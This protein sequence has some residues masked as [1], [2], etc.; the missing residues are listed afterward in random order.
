MQVGRNWTSSGG[1]YALGH[2]SLPQHAVEGLPVARPRFA[3]PPRVRTFGAGYQVSPGVEAPERYI[4]A[5]SVCGTDLQPFSPW[6]GRLGATLGAKVGVEVLIT[7]PKRPPHRLQGP[8]RTPRRARSA[9]GMDCLHNS[10]PGALT[11]GET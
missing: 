2:F 8:L 11:P 10:R 1:M 5:T 6:E 4:S 7:N 3:H 9:Q